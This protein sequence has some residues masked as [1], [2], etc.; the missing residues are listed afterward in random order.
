MKE[1][2]QTQSVLLKT[3]PESGNLSAKLLC[4]CLKSECG[5]TLPVHGRVFTE[6]IVFVNCF[7][8]TPH[9]LKYIDFCL[10]H[11]QGGSSF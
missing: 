2:K 10:K 9:Y 4:E 1:Y 11:R 6:M 5:T 8:W 3:D 7:I